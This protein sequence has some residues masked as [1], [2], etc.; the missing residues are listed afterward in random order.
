[1]IWFLKKGVVC[2]NTIL[3]LPLTEFLEQK[4]AE[5]YEG[6][7]ENKPVDII[8]R[9]NKWLGKDREKNK[10]SIFNDAVSSGVL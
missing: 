8:Q 4:I 7:S 10:S 6:W 1:M 9:K 5:D 2:H 3:S